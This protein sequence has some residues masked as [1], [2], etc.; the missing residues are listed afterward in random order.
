MNDLLI[1][2][3]CFVGAFLAGSIPWG[4]VVGKLFGVDPRMVGSGNIGATNVARALGPLGFVAVYLLDGVSG[5]LPVFFL[6]PIATVFSTT[7]NGVL[8][9][10]VVIL[11]HVFT[12]WLGFRGGKGVAT[13]SGVT[14]ALA[15]WAFVAALACFLV[16]LLMTRIVSI[17]SLAASVALPLFVIYFTGIKGWAPDDY[18]LLGYS[19][20][21]TVVV[22]ITHRR[23]MGRLF[24]GT[25]ARVGATKKK[26]E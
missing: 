11:G 18:W 2:I 13:A 15:L 3:A 9:G 19:L 22:F 16:I 26:E 21:I 10:I 8:L 20:L 23:N 14:V 7:G 4:L 5:F 25:E 1:N 24:N 6:S 12:P 17:S